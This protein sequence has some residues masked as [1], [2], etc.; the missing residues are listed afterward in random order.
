M[1]A[2]VSH[3]TALEVLRRWDLRG[4]LA[5]G[6]RCVARVPPRP[7][8]GRELEEL[9]APGTLLGSL[10]RPIDMLVADG[11]GRTR[12]CDVR[13]HLQA[14]PLPEG[15]AVDLGEGLLCTSPEHLPVQMA[16]RLTDLELTFLLSELLGLYAI[17]PSQDEGM[18]QRDEP[19]TTPDR[20]LAHLARLGGRHGVDRVRRALGRACVRSGSPRETKLA[21]RFSLRPA[22]G[23][24][25][26][27]LLSMNEGLAVR[28]LGERMRPGVRRPDILIGSPDGSEVV[29]VEYLGRKHE[30]P[31]RMVQDVARTNELKALG[32]SEYL[33]RR[34][35]YDDLDYMDA[36]AE[37]IRGELGYPRVGLTRASARERRERREE[38]YRELEHIDGVSWLGRKRE[39]ARA[40]MRSTG[41][42][43][44]E[45]VPV[46]AYG[47]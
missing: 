25:H 26:L 29:A 21:L 3:T 20:V 17:D 43:A 10:P 9:L 45:L 11:R 28:R 35:Q 16:S 36:L 30:L 18:F 12:S 15:S 34:E 42:G 5:R 7:P 4:R 41:E 44:C 14:E 6:E 33:V 22:L 8:S 27:N 37:K 19:L 40:A 1:D 46:E 24:W 47:A 2:F 32:V 13:A 38:L 39:R 23:G 31:A